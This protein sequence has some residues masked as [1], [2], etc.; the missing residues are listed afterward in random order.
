MTKGFTLIEIMVAVS[1]LTIGV[2]GVYALVPT[3]IKTNA[4]NTDRFI[5]SQLA[6]EGMELV[7][8]IRDANWLRQ[9]DWAEG[10]TACAGGCEMDY[11]DPS[12]I[13]FQNRFL[14]ID[15]NGFYNYK[16]GTSTTFTRKITITPL[17]DYF[18]IKV[19]IIWGSGN[20][21]STVEENLYD[22][23]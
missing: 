8:N 6:R 13:S 23:R 12:L 14:K 7:R 2:V 9:V 21:S 3:V 11:N 4:A 16:N 5:A 20:S 1:V 17:I 19:Q 18:N 22:W 10:L 15:G